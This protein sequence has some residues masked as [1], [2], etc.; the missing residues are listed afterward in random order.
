MFVIHITDKKI[1]SQ[2]IKKSYR[3]MRKEQNGNLKSMGKSD[4]SYFLEEA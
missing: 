2:Y 3:S 1:E 4:N